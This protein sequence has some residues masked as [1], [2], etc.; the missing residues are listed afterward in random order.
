MVSGF[1]KDWEMRMEKEMKV[2]GLACRRWEVA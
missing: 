2:K 1:G